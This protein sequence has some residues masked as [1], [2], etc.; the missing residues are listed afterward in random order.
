MEDV[1]AQCECEA[2]HTHC[3]GYRETRA[4]R[5]N[6]MGFYFVKNSTGASSWFQLELDL[7][8]EEWRAEW[9]CLKVLG[10]AEP[11]PASRRYHCGWS[12]S[13]QVD[14]GSGGFVTLEV[15]PLCVTSEKNPIPLRWKGVQNQSIKSW[16]WSFDKVIYIIFKKWF[17]IKIHIF[18][19]NWMK[20]WWKILFM[21]TN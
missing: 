18:L 15:F 21:I 13:A 20:Q 9:V 4:Q 1:V 8:W 6:I 11:R 10:E 19:K 14:R 16:K 3:E 17:L 7:P 5:F 2:T 12:G